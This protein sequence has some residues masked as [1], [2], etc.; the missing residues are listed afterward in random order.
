L[1]LLLVHVA[2]DTIVVCLYLY[3]CICTSVSVHLYL[4]ICICTCVCVCVCLIPLTSLHFNRGFPRRQRR[5]SW[6]RMAHASC[7]SGRW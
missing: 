3:I 6:R 5:T 7:A 4:Y 2:M 1:S